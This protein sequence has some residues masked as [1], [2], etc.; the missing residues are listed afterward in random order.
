MGVCRSTSGAPL[1]QRQ[2]HREGER[3]GKDR[4]RG[5]N[6]GRNRQGDCDGDGE[7]GEGGA[8]SGGKGGGIREVSVSPQGAPFPVSS[9]DIRALPRVSL[10]ALGRTLGSR[11]AFGREQ[12]VRERSGDVLAV[13]SS[14]EVGGALRTPHR[15]LETRSQPCEGIGGVHWRESERDGER[16]RWQLQKPRPFRCGRQGSSR[17]LCR[18]RRRHLGTALWLSLGGSPQALHSLSVCALR[19]CGEHSL[20]SARRTRAADCARRQQAPGVRSNGQPPPPRQAQQAPLPA[21]RP[22][23]RQAWR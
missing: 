11:R 6:S 23:P 7:G 17:L 4:D 3:R 19:Q 14:R 21:A 1:C 12:R 10:F 5:S 9:G 15:E 2:R 18:C 16:A 13:R 8:R 20:C 22:G